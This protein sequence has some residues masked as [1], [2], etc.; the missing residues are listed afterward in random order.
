M[1]LIGKVGLMGGGSWATAIAKIVLCTQPSISW[2]LRTAD[3]VKEFKRL[4]HNPKYLSS[5]HFDIDTINFFSDNDVNDFFRS[6][7]TIILAIPS[8]YV[9]TYLKR[10]RNSIIADKVIINAVKGIVPDEN[11]LVNEYLQKIKGVSKNKIAVL[12]GPCHAEEVANDSLSYLTVGAFDINIAKGMKTIL[13]NDFVHCATSKDVVGIEYAS[14]LK[15]IYA[16]AA[17]ICNGLNYGDNF[18]SVLISNAI[19]EMQ[20]FINTVHLIDRDVTES[21]YLGDL[22]VTAYSNYSRNRTF[23]NM[24]GKG[25][26]V[27]A[28]Q[29]E[30]NMVAEGYYGA[31]C[32]KEINKRYQINMPI[33]RAVYEILY[34]KK[35]PKIAI[36]NLTNF[37]K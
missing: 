19:A 9:K 36:N 10:V 24:I 16:I 18:Q 23:G 20:Y 31:K 30:M 5:V 35:A 3:H 14:V 33:S 25:Y 13:S 28:A 29:M 12:S 34:E 7:D 4:K 37:F 26:S 32:I 1:E 8:P 27:K 2:Y 11:L 21:V 15:N 17:G 22:L 6:C